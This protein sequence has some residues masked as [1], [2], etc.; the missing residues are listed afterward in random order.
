MQMHMRPHYQ[1]NPRAMQMHMRPHSQRN[2]QAM[3]VKVQ[4]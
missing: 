2:A 1:R 3:P 4:I